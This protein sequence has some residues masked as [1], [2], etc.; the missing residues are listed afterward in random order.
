MQSRCQKS[1]ETLH[2]TLVQVMISHHFSRCRVRQ[3]RSSA[4]VA[5]P[6]G[7]E[8]A[9]TPKA[10]NGLEPGIKCNQCTNSDTALVLAM[11]GAKVAKKGKVGQGPR[12]A[13]KAWVYIR[14][15]P[16]LA[17]LVF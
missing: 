9:E 14:L 3:G 11:Q 16:L 4:P 15:A 7:Q 10:R 8:T 2:D 6:S 1:A 13:A 17:V 5:A 12:Q